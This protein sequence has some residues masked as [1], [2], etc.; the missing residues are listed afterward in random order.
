MT[1]NYSAMKS[2]FVYSKTE[3][4]ATIIEETFNILSWSERG[5]NR[6]ALETRTQTYWRDFLQDLEGMIF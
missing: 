3:L 4:D 1:N 5:S 6:Y 2:A